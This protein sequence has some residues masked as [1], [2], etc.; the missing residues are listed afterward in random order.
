MRWIWIVLVSLIGC[1]GIGDKTIDF[2]FKSCPIKNGKIV[3]Y[4]NSSFSMATPGNAATII[5]N[6]SIVYSFTDGVVIG[7]EEINGSRGFTLLIETPDGAKVVYTN[8][9]EYYVGLE[10]EVEEGKPLG[11]LHLEGNI[12]LTEFYLYQSNRFI[13]PKHVLGCKC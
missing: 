7:V 6:D 1:N 4:Q 2:P 8:I 5:G 12:F 13:D 10:E 3:S 9:N 11:I